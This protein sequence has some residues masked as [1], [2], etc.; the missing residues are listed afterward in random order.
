MKKKVEFRLITVAGDFILENGAVMGSRKQINTL[1]RPKLGVR[2]S[3]LQEVSRK[4]QQDLE[5]LIA[6]NYRSEDVIIRKKAGVFYGQ[7]YA[8]FRN[9]GEK[10]MVN[11]SISHSENVFAVCFSA[12]RLVGIDLQSEIKAEGSSFQ[13]FFSPE[14][15]KVLTMLAIEDGFTLN[16]AA[17]LIWTIKEAFLKAVGVGFRFGFNSLR[18]VDIDWKQ[19]EMA[20]LYSDQVSKFFDYDQELMLYI[21]PGTFPVLT[22]VA[23]NPASL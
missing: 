10:T 11:V 18:V 8:L 22:I 3:V 5:A 23:I 17:T 20:L 21:A 1:E 16:K 2:A 12:S 15:S 7:P 6:E 4:A 14:E 19:G 9:N 13:A